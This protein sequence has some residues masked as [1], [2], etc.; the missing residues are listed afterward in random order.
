VS[1]H[2]CPQR[3]GLPEA[4][5][6]VPEFCDAAL[7]VNPHQI[8]KPLPGPLAGRHGALPRRQ[9]DRA[10]EPCAAFL[11]PDIVWVEEQP[12]GRAADC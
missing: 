10:S 4:V 8:G 2:A 11:Y 12:P 3:S 5:P 6:A 1:T 7:A 9:P